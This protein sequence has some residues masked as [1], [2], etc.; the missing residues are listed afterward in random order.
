MA[1]CARYSRC[2]RSP[3]SCRC[4]RPADSSFTR[5]DT[6]FPR[7]SSRTLRITPG[8]PG[9]R[10]GHVPAE[11]RPPFRAL[12]GRRARGC[13]SEHVFPRSRLHRAAGAERGEE[14]RALRN[15]RRARRRAATVG[16]HARCVDAALCAR[17][18][19]PQAG[20]RGHRDRCG[21]LLAVGP[22][23][24]RDRP[25]PDRDDDGRHGE[26]PPRGT[27]QIDRRRRAPRTHRRRVAATPD[28]ARPDPLLR[29]TRRGRARPLDRLPD[30]RRGCEGSVAAVLDRPA[31]PAPRPVLRPLPRAAPDHPADPVTARRQRVRRV[32]RRL[33]RASQSSPLRGSRAAGAAASGTRRAGD[34]GDAA[35]PQ[36]LQG[37]QR[38]ARPRGGG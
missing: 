18:S 19:L 32:A 7:R 38:H 14:S 6:P 20:G 24:L 11:P 33:D 9:E 17:R 26:R 27:R 5:G 31:A 37:G 1:A 29:R 3:S 25:S 4:S 21:P 22:R 12:H 15:E 28:G 10:V 13:G 23:R 35:R 36:P 2:S 30:D 16:L 34:H 8:A